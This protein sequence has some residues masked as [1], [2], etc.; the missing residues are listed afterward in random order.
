MADKAIT[1][2]TEDTSPTSDDL[3]VL[4]NDAAGTPANKKATLTNIITKAHGLGNGV[5][6]ISSGT[7]AVATAGTDYYNP[8]G[9]DVA[10][11][12]GGTGASTATNARTNLGVAIGSDVQ[13][14]NANTALTTNKLSDFAAT[15]SAEMRTVISD[16]T[17]SSGGLVF[18]GS[19]TL[20]TPTIGDLTNMTHS[21]QNNAGGGTLN[22]AAIAAGTVATARLGSGTPNATN[23][24][25]GDQTWAVVSAGASIG[26][27]TANL[28]GFNGYY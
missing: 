16:E 23:F 3:T 26:L 17:G 19:P 2:L 13:A 6:K 12:D 14:Y 8:G 1:G 21:H 4:V 9:T 5:L 10:V 24:L 28:N 7:M 27:V 20:T 22:A 11:A 25:R 15:T 18:A